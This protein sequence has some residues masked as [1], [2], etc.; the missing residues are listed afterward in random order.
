M[1]LP[2]TLCNTIPA[3]MLDDDHKPVLGAV[4]GGM[5]GP[6]FRPIAQAAVYQAAQA[7]GLRHSHHRGGRD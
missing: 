5:S 1:P 7:K 2:V 6:W 3:M 4:T